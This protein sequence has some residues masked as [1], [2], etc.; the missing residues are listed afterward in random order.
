MPSN[1]RSCIAMLPSGFREIR[2]RAVNGMDLP[3]SMFF[4]VAI[5]VLHLHCG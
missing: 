2:V 4:L 5:Y 1:A 3:V